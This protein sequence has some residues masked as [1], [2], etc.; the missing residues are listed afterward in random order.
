MVCEDRSP[1]AKRGCCSG[2]NGEGARRGILSAQGA[3]GHVSWARR[4]GDDG[5][6]LF[7]RWQSGKAGGEKAKVQGDVDGQR[8]REGGC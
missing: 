6:A 8:E 2:M 7:C 4:A 5:T 1:V 3:C